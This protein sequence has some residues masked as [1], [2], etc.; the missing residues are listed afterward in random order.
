M[1]DPAAP[2]PK[3]TAL[4]I[5][6]IMLS[7]LCMLH[8]LALPIAIT[9]FPILQ[10][11]LLQETYFHAIML[12]LI[13]PASLIALTIGCRQHRDRSVMVLGG[14][15]LVTLT[16]TALFGH[17]VLGHDGERLATTVGGV[18]LALAHIQNFRACR[19]DNCQHDH[20]DDGVTSQSRS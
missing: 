11:T 20:D 14:I 7:G 2:H 17:D 15:G 16:L 6:A 10:V 13:L 19:A 8:C 1:S 9:L 12:I 3:S 18:I 5:A 4:D